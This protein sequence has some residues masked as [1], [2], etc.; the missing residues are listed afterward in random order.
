MEHL[1]PFHIGDSVV[2]P[3][4]GLG[5]VVRLAEKSFFGQEAGLYY[6]VTIQQG[7]VWVPVAVREAPGLRPVTARGDLARYRGLLKGPP[8][9]LDQDHRKRHLELVDRLRQGSFQILCE[10]VRDLAARGWAKPL[11]ESDAASLR[12][13]RERLCAEWAASDGVSVAAAFQ[14][15]E[16]LL[17][18]SRQKHHA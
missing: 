5:R 4:H 10:V 14:E 15:V 8:V 2:H 16:S 12:R 7:T 6:E 1:Q 18:E 9:S 17:L 11:G 3:A 13:A